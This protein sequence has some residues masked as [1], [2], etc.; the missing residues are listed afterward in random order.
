[1][2]AILDAAG[3]LLRKR[4]GITATQAKGTLRLVLRDLGVEAKSATRADWLRACGDALKDAL[5]KRHVRCDDA[6]LR[7]LRKV[8][9]ETPDQDEDALGF[10]DDIE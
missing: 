9:A 7:E 6:L 10:F 8:V 5:D 1:M 2:S 3:A 4:A